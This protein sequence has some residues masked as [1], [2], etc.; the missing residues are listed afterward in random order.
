MRYWDIEKL[1]YW[2]IGIQRYKNTKIVEY[3]DIEI[4]TD[5]N[6]YI[7]EYREIGEY[8]FLQN[9]TNILNIL[10]TY[11]GYYIIVSSVNWINIWSIL[12]WLN[13][14]YSPL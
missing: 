9:I 13:G 1:K 12:F 3:R 8:D 10:N 14:S 7:L 2:D 6:K 5:W 4:Q 11:I